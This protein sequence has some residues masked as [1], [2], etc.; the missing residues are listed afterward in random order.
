MSATRRQLALLLAILIL[1]AVSTA[2]V[3]MLTG[4]GDATLRAQTLAF[5][6]RLTW[7]G[8]V[9]EVRMNA[10]ADLDP[11]QHA[12]LVVAP[13][14]AFP[15]DDIIALSGFLA[16][17]GRA[18]VAADTGAGIDLVQRLDLGVTLTDV[19]VYS[20][21][22]SQDPRRIVARSTG[23]IDAM[24]DEV[25]LDRPVLVQGGH[26][27]LLPPDLAWEDHNGNGLPDLDEP[28]A[29]GSFAALA[30]LAEGALLV[31]G[32]PGAVAAGTP[33]HA[34][35]LSWLDGGGARTLVLDASHGALSDPLGV[36]PA[37]GWRIPFLASIGILIV[38]IGVGA[39]VVLAPRLRRREPARGIGAR[40]RRGDAPRD[41]AEIIGE[42]DP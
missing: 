2:P 13:R 26:S 28:L 23:V 33:T 17:G 4:A 30:P 39:F 35:L 14:A 38:A 9:V 31:V 34:P 18:L 40:A 10:L 3:Q 32:D 11:G 20:P 15:E 29:N 5:P 21:D 37:A 27:V 16:A 7:E 22:F 19:R 41:L 25:T 6:A 24:P 36:G 1:L 42:L 8:R 12:L